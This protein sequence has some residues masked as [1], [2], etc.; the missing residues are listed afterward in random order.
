MK[1]IALIVIHGAMLFLAGPMHAHADDFYMFV[2]VRCDQARAKLLISFDGVTNEKGAAMA[3]AHQKNRW[4]TWDLIS[5][6]EEGNGDYSVQE[7][8]IHA[9]CKLSSKKYLIELAPLRG[10][11]YS[12]GGFCAAR[13]GATVTVTV[14][15][16]KIA[17]S[18]ND[19]CSDEGWVAKSILITP[20]QNPKYKNVPAETFFED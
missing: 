10:A 11:G 7:Q 18:G 2:N 13:M 8:P 12:P 15:G 1:K 9:E 6:K 3:L 4:N 16:E 20:G 5:M 19:G 17:R 14:A